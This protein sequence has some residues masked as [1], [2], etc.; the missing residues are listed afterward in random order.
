MIK[1]FRKIDIFSE[2]LLTWIQPW[3]KKNRYFLKNIGLWPEFALILS[4]RIILINLIVTDEKCP[5]NC[6]FWPGSSILVLSCK[7][8]YLKLWQI[9]LGKNG[10]NL[11]STELFKKNMS[12]VNTNKIQPKQ[13]ANWAKT[14]ENR[15][16]SK[17]FGLLIYFL[18]TLNLRN[19]SLKI[20]E[21][22]SAW[23]QF[24]PLTTSFD[25]I[26]LAARTIVCRPPFSAGRL[27][28]L[29]NFEKGE[30]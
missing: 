23:A 15:P 4:C 7:F 6:N 22:W 11:L 1:R 17:P 29:P 27:N 19:E 30:F 26:I 18:G 2:I 5:G 13:K 8:S 14:P 28:L 20:G 25:C 21:M 24:S 12:E 9:F 3:Y 10:V 16:C